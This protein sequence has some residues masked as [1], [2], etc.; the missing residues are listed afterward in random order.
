MNCP[1]ASERLTALLNDQLG[2]PERGKLEAHLAV[3]P[4]CQQELSAL[5]AV[6]ALL[7]EHL[8]REEAPLYFKEEAFQQFRLTRIERLLE[9]LRARFR[10]RWALTG[11]PFAAAV[12]IWAFFQVHEGAR[13]SA[14]SL[15]Q[16]AVIN[17]VD[18]LAGKLPVE[19]A[20][21]DPFQV[22]AWFEGK[23]PFRVE[24]PDL[25]G[26]GVRLLGGR[27]C[28]IQGYNVAYVTYHRE[29][30]PLSLFVLDG[31]NRGAPGEDPP[32]VISASAK[33]YQSVSWKRGEIGY[34]LVSDLDRET[35]REIA[36]H[37]SRK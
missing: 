15:V 3:C 27:L 7:K 9:G 16:A 13:S 24:V 6:G 37:A 30:H 12:L 35:L 28:H 26:E 4:L 32:R 17:H 33:G 19:V 10:L 23:L 5:Q 11:I 18:S 22:S 20:G 2:Y 8:P 31:T 14:D 36:T 1:E 29:G 25:S 21:T 34:L